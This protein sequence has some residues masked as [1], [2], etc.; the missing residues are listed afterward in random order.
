MQMLFSKRPYIN[1]KVCLIKTKQ[2]DAILKNTKGNFL[3]KS[4]KSYIN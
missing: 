2:I 1:A 4:I 3:D